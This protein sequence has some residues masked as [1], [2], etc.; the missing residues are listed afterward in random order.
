M[1]T[2][3]KLAPNMTH[4]NVVTVLMGLHPRLGRRCPYQDLPDE[5]MKMIFRDFC[6]KVFSLA[7][8][9]SLAYFSVGH[10]KTPAWEW[11]RKFMLISE[12][13]I[14]RQ[15][16]NKRFTVSIAGDG[17]THDQA[18]AKRPFAGCSSAEMVFRDRLKF[19]DDPGVLCNMQ[20]LINNHFELFSHPRR[21]FPAWTKRCWMNQVLM[22]EPFNPLIC[23]DMPTRV[24][25]LSEID[26]WLRNLFGE[27]NCDRFVRVREVENNTVNCLQWEVIGTHRPESG[28]LLKNKNL[29]NALEST[30]TFTQSVWN[31]FGISGRLQAGDYVRSGDTYLAPQSLCKP[32]GFQ[33]FIFGPNVNVADV[34]TS[35]ALKHFRAYHNSRYMFL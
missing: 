12:V 14:P 3:S 9:A 27:Q 22:F 11:L 5:L 35:Y 4:S 30:S 24:V 16:E 7:P 18:G 34:M 8:A 28:R 21:F 29:S 6:Y 2:C 19:N 10:L 25:K 26:S 17:T 23:R 32:I 15:I 1:R 33:I 13:G 20:I 31:T